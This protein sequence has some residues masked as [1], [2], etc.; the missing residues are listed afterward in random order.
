MYRWECQ[1]N[2]WGRVAY[3]PQQQL[4]NYTKPKIVSFGFKP[5]VSITSTIQ[6]KNTT[7][8]WIP[9][10]VYRSSIFTELCIIYLGENGKKQGKDTLLDPIHLLIGPRFSDK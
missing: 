6:S 4:E 5:S 7:H 3:F 2:G 9:Y 10:S 1:C 8:K